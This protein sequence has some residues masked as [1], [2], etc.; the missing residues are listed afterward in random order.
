M[1][2][3]DLTGII[4]AGGKSE[5]IGKDKRFLRLNGT[6]LIDY[7]IQ[8]LS[9]ITSAIIIASGKEQFAYKGFTC[10]QDI[11][12]IEGP[13]AGLIPALIYM[14]TPYAI[15]LPCDMPFVPKALFSFFISLI[16]EPINII[17]P[18]ISG[19]LQP[20]VGIYSKL[21]IEELYPFVKTGESSLSKLITSHSQMVRVVTQ[22]ELEQ[23]GFRKDLFLNINTMDDFVCASKMDDR[24]TLNG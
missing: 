13:I 18:V 24:C 5:R 17:I 11:T 10:I 6:Y 7:S 8:T 3:Q 4:L 23:A 20:L 19:R 12:Q 14:H 2:K 21:L 15:V 9:N 1:I 22:D 16:K